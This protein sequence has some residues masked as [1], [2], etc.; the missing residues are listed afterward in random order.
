MLLDAKL[1]KPLGPLL[2]GIF[3]FLETRAKRYL[4]NDGDTLKVFNT[5]EPQRL[6]DQEICYRYKQSSLADCERGSVL[7][8]P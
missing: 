7:D 6:S 8:E 1:P 2:E 3:I 5:P 4:T